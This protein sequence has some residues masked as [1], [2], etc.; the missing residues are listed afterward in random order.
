M[1]ARSPWFIRLGCRW[2][3][4]ASLVTAAACSVSQDRE[5]AMGEKDAAKIESEVPVVHDT[6]VDRFVTELGRSMAS[7]T[8]RADLDWHFTVVNSPEV[9]AFALPGGFVYVNRGAIEQAERLD[10]LAGIMG[11]EIGH[12]VRRHGVEQMQKTRRGE[13]GLVLLCTLTRACS[14]IGGRVAVDVGANA[15]SAHYSQ[16][17]EAQ[18]D[19]EG[20]LNTVRAGIDPEGLPSFFQKLLETQKEQPDKVE[21]FFS[22]HPT[23]QARISATRQ[24]I[25]R[26]DPAPGPALMRDTPE[27]HTIQARVRALPAPPPP[28]AADRK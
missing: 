28:A 5:V 21:A 24:Q 3:A 20:V 9:N 18:A 23:D 12:V 19:S 4:V 7:R 10:E 14:T 6:A 25:A 2:V 15:L 1:Q 17:D 27:F 13:V 26:L 11:H 22:T 8:R 16:R